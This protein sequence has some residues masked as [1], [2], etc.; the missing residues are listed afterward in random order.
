MNENNNN[1][2]E[3]QGN[4]WMIQHKATNKQAQSKLTTPIQN[5]AMEQCNEAMQ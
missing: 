2:W 4:E 1:K 3:Q 5:G